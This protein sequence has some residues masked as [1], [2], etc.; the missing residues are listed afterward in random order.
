LDGYGLVEG[1]LHDYTTLRSRASFELQ[2]KQRFVENGFLP[3]LRTYVRTITSIDDTAQAQSLLEDALQGHE[4][5]RQRSIGE[6]QAIVAELQQASRELNSDLQAYRA[7]MQEVDYNRGVYNISRIMQHAKWQPIN[8]TN[9][10]ES[11][12]AMKGIS[13]DLHAVDKKRS[14]LMLAY[15]N[16]LI[17]YGNEVVKEAQRQGQEPYKGDIKPEIIAKALFERY[18]EVDL[19]LYKEPLWDRV[20][21]SIGK[22]VQGIRQRRAEPTEREPEA[23]PEVQPV[24]LELLPANFRRLNQLIGQEYVS[25]RGLLSAARQRRKALARAR[26]LGADFVVPFNALNSNPIKAFEFYRSY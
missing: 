13:A 21:Q 24:Y 20:K 12:Q 22:T 17:G 11:L 10:V 8:L 7:D 15:F 25:A 9:V 3:E 16:E 19:G 26:E 23:E 1:L 18:E 2:A 14:G 6:N 4:Q 5:A